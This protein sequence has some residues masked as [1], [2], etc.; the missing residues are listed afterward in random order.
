MRIWHF[1]IIFVVAA[2]FLVASCGDSNYF[3]NF[4]PD[5]TVAGDT[6]SVDTVFVPTDSCIWEVVTVC[7]WERNIPRRG[8]PKFILRCHTTRTLICESARLSD[9]RPSPL[10]VREM[11]VAF[12]GTKTPGVVTRGF[13]AFPHPC[14]L[15]SMR[16]TPS[17]GVAPPG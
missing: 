7:I 9:Y 16:Q 13:L 15:P 10:P 3:S 1:T 2:W 5:S 12:A 4:R 14:N 17:H 11:A 6:A 8:G